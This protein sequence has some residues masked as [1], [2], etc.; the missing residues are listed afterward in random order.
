MGMLVLGV[1]IIAFAAVYRHKGVHRK[2]SLKH[3][4]AQPRENRVDGCISPGNAV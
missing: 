1:A 2:K 3:R 4:T